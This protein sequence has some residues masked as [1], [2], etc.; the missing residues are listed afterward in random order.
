MHF[1]E[2]KDDYIDYCSEFMSPPLKK[3]RT[4][5]CFKW[6][7]SNSGTLVTSSLET[8]LVGNIAAVFW[9]KLWWW[10]C[11][12]LNSSTTCGEDTVPIPASMPRPIFIAVYGHPRFQTRWEE[13][14]LDGVYNKIT[15]CLPVR[16]SR[17]QFWSLKVRTLALRKLILPTFS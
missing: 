12:L 11:P 3:L 13:L 6:F 1:I 16:S 15:R 9:V 7:S 5:P 10:W 8:W 14:W 17:L 4:L 2:M